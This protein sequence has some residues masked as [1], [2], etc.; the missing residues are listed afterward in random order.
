VIVKT[1]FLAQWERLKKEFDSAAKAVKNSNDSTRAFIAMMAKPTGLTP[2][3]KD[4]DAAFAKGHRKPANE[5]LLKFYAKREPLAVLFMKMLPKLEDDGLMQVVLKL[6][7]ELPALEK[8]MQTKLKELQDE[9]AGESGASDWNLLLLFETDLAKNI[10][11]LSRDLKP[12]ALAAIEKKQGVLKLPA[13]AVAHMNAY[14]K[15]AARLNAADALASL[16]AFVVAAEK[17]ADGCESILKKE[18]DAAYT[19][20]VERF[21]KDLRTLCKARV[22]VQLKKLEEHAR[23]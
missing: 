17:C 7:K 11:Q 9:K 22:A 10:D 16:K 15:A 21:V 6:N 20:A 2:I 4:I 1:D 19:K 18:D 12:A 3:L 5:A 13:P 8:S 23:G 14:S